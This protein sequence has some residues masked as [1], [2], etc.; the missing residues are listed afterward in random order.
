M[1]KVFPARLGG[2]ANCIKVLLVT[3][4]LVSV[5]ACSS[6]APATSEPVAAEPAMSD[7][8]MAKSESAP[9]SASGETIKVGVLHSLSG[10]MSISETAVKDATL[11]AIEE[12]NAAGGV[13]GKQLEPVIEDGASD[14]PTFAEKARKLI[15]SDEV[16]VVFGGW[17][18][19]SRKAMLPVFESNNGLLFYPVQYEGLETSP[20][21][22]YTGATTNQQIVPAVEY[23]LQQGNTK[24]YLLGSDYV[25]PRTSNL[26][27]NKQLKAAGLEAVGE[28]YTPLGHTE[29]STVIAKIKS[30]DPD[31]VF[32][33]LN[34]DSNV[35]FFKQLKDAGIT[36]EDLTTVSV[37]VAE[38]EITGIGADNMMGHLVAWNYF[39]TTDTPENT[40]FVAAFK[41]KY[42][43]NRVTDDPIEA[44]YFG[45]YIWAKAVEKAGT[46]DVA[47]VKEAAK[48]LEFQAPGGL[49]TVHDTNQHVAKTVRIG[50]VRD[51]GQ[52][53]EIWNSGAP[54]VP[55][56]YLDTYEWAA[57]LRESVQ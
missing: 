45:T 21:I 4:L 23:L 31:V 19:A 9:E 40:K 30:A 15:Q 55:D 11:L 39:Q 57:G 38:E 10:T 33:T 24:F 47:A 43:E 35:A 27:I 26:I 16:V 1:F 7:E 34:G 46:T 48:G 12:I 29:Y 53:N 52:V 36:P 41:A 13:L 51:D 32:N 49:V 22:F 56:P 18:S 37:S 20:N 6:A 50:S 14:W 8:S 2:L 3:L 42:G 28:E 44:G 54:V 25:F 17:T 5:L